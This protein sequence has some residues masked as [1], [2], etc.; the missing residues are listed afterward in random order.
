MYDKHISL[1]LFRYIKREN[2]F[3]RKNVIFDMSSAHYIRIKKND[4]IF[5]EEMGYS[6][7]KFPCRL[8]QMGNSCSMW[9]YASLLFLLQDKIIDLEFNDNT[10]YKIVEILY[11]L[12]DIKEKDFEKKKLVNIYTNKYSQ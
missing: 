2:R 11:D 6:L 4:P 8:T 3:L 1:L 5:D 7:D 10:L 12:F 9:F